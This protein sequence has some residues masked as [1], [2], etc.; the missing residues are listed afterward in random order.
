MTRRERAIRR[1]MEARVTRWLAAK[2]AARPI[3]SPALSRAE[4]L[5]AQAV[6]RRETSR[7]ANIR[8]RERHRNDAAFRAQWEPVVNPQP[9][10]REAA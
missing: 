3:L 10:P 7:R 5:A 9:R 6:R 4:V 1:I 8:C 2:H